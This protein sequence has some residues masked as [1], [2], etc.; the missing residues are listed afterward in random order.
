MAQIMLSPSHFYGLDVG[1]TKIELAVYDS[2]LQLRYSKRIATPTRDYATFL[3]AVEL[4]V[5]EADA[6]LHTI[7]AVGLGIPGVVDAASGQH[8]SANVPA[9]NG[10]NLRT[11]L[12][13][14]LERQVAIGND[15]H[16]FALSEANGGAAHGYP[17]MFGAILG[18]GVGGGYC[19]DGVLASGRNGQAGEW[20]HWSVSAAL[21]ARHGLPLLGADGNR[22][23]CLEHY[24]AGSGLAALYQIVGG[25]P[26]DARTIVERAGDHDVLAVRALAI[27]I[28]LL[29]Q[30]LA[31]LVLALDPHVIV[32]GGGLSNMAH[33][34]HQLPLAMRR[35]LLD[36]VVPPPILAPVFGDAGGAR[37]AALLARARQAANHLTY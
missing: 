2:T 17:S 3:Q 6:R 15:C 33:L 9:I 32:L 30:G 37:G 28:D 16:C 14:R 29:A 8:Q 22:A 5:R 31:S 34:Y 4:L 23:G 19:V 21:L 27:H 25:A 18:T 1:G 35:H 12:Q 11:D 36:D 13:Q 26:R 24:L 10:A 7:G 20:G